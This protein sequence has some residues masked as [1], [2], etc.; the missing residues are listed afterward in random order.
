MS[1]NQIIEALKKYLEKQPDDWRY[2]CGRTSM[3]KKEVLERLKKD[4]KFRKNMTEQI[5]NLTIDL[6]TRGSIS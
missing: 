2:I 1:E 3:S 6:W 5:V 4:K